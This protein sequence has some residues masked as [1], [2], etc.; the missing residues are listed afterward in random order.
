VA[1]EARALFF[2]NSSSA[3]AESVRHGVGIALLPTYGLVFE[4]G[5][6]TLDIG[7][8]FATPFWLCYHKDALAKQS[9]RI[10]VQFLKHIFNRKS[11]P[12]FADE[13]VSPD[14][15]PVITTAEVMASFSSAGAVSSTIAAV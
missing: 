11:M 12:W 15:F 1:E 5:F 10:A 3:L 2:T 9:A 8:H 13:F 4:K 6:E 14:D 7:L